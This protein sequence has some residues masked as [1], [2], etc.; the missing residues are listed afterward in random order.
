[1]VSHG[2]FKAAQ[3]VRWWHSCPLADRNTW[4]RVT[5]NQVLQEY[6]SQWGNVEKKW[7]LEILPAPK[8]QASASKIDVR[9]PFAKP[10]QKR[11]LYQHILCLRLGT[12]MLV[13]LGLVTQIV[14]TF[15]LNS[16]LI[17]LLFPLQGE[18]DVA[19]GFSFVARLLTYSEC[20][21]CPVPFCS[22]EISSSLLS[23][24]RPH[25][26]TLA[27]NLLQIVSLNYLL[28]HCFLLCLVFACGLFLVLSTY[29]S[30]LHFLCSSVLTCDFSWWLLLLKLLD[31]KKWLTFLLK[32]G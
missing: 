22:G 28:I 18:L 13:T 26:S 32:E 2:S 4:K 23:S 6:K 25:A 15:N 9:Y 3:A 11:C 30:F 8:L 10:I 31:W 24:W 16:L 1:M 7:D 12:G 17:A 29:M 19:S 5:E 27:I 20:S 14:S 21:H